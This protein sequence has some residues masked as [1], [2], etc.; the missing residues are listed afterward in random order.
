MRAKNLPMSIDMKSSS[1]DKDKENAIDEEDTDP[2]CF[3]G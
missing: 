3:D 2:P 1:K